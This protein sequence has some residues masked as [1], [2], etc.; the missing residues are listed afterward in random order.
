VVREHIETPSSWRAR[1]TLQA[2]LERHGVPGISEIDTRALVRRIRS[3]GAQN[4]VLVHGEADP[5]ELVARARALPAMEG[6][7]L[8]EAVTCQQPYEWRGGDPW[9]ASGPTG[10]RRATPR[11]IVAYDLGIKR[12]IL[13]LLADQGFEVTVVPAGTS[14]AQ[15]LAY[16]PDG[17]FLSNGPGDPSAVPDVCESVRELIGQKPIFGICLGH[18]ILGLALG[19]RSRKLRFGHH[20][21]NQ[22]ARE[23]ATGRVLITSENHGFA[24]DEQPLADDPDVEITHRNLNDGTIEG[25][26]H[27]RLPIFSVQYHPE[28]SPGPHDSAELFSHFSSLIEEDRAQAS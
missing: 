18:Q 22:P 27:R 20:G 4:A 28:A 24:L 17:I 26:R 7:N 6:R 23:A 11:R 25:L 2:Y 14:A 10:Q 15:A 9:T 12:N 16:E 21:A 13:R 8:V 19:G 1:E 5:H 3:A